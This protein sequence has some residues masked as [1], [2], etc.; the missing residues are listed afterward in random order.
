MA[1]RVGQAPVE[2]SQRGLVQCDEGRGGGVVVQD[3][4]QAGLPRGCV[5][6]AG[7][8][9]DGESALRGGLGEAVEPPVRGFVPGAQEPFGAVDEGD[10]AVAQVREVVDTGRGQRGVVEAD[11]PVVL[12]PRGAADA[13]GGEVLREEVLDPVVVESDLHQDRAVDAA[14]PQQPL[15][16][17]VAVH[18][19]R[20]EQYVVVVG[21]RRLH[22]AADEV[23][24]H[25]GVVIAGGREDQT[26]GAGTAVGQ[27]P[28][29]G[30]G[31][32]AQVV[33]DSL[34]LLAGLL[35]HRALAAQRVRHGAPRDTGPLGDLTDVHGHSFIEFVRV[36]RVRPT[37]SNRFA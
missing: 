20:G 24:L 2:A 29:A 11:P 15:E 13:D 9:T 4:L 5:V 35:R 14:L 18:A 3:P 28:C 30:V 17:A 19:A 7:V 26:E 23:E 1:T 10:P 36:H 8:R 27:G 32:V 34:D 37:S 25:P 22:H 31:P 6:P 16:R 12:R 33:D 21:G